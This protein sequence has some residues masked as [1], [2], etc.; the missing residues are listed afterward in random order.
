VDAQSV[1]GNLIASLI[2]FLAGVFFRSGVRH[3]REL[4][5]GRRTLG[6]AG[7]KQVTIVVSDKGRAEAEAQPALYEADVVAAN[8]IYDSLHRL[9]PRTRVAFATATSLTQDGLL[10]GNL[11]I[12]GG[13][14]TNRAHRTVASLLP[15]PFE[16][17]S[18]AGQAALV[19]LQDG[20]EF[21]HQVDGNGRTI[22]DFGLIVLARNPFQEES[23]VVIV[24]GC[25]TLGTVAA[26][27]ALTASPPQLIPPQLIRS[28]SG[29]LVVEIEVIEGFTTRPQVVAASA[30]PE[31][32]APS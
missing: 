30:L 31:A 29:V 32:P 20:Q 18:V 14:W 22:R 10:E 26:A 1:L 28:R 5:P 23:R 15:L 17:R 2:A 6:L 7:G 24:A 19:R 8:T 3:W 12:V 4:R 11:V 9:F 13:P 25:G 16:F 21:P 27:G